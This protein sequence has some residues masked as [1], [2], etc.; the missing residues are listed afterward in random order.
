MAEGEKIDFLVIGSQKCA[1]TWLYDCLKDCPTLNLRNSKNEDA[2]YGGAMFREKGEKWYFSQFDNKDGDLQKGCI[3]VEYIEDSAVPA[4][5]YQLNPDI[6]I[7]ASL[8]H[9]V[10]RALS[11][12]QWYVRKSYIPDLPLQQGIE[13]AMK[14]FRGEI[15]DS[16]TSAYKNIIE[17][18]F[19]AERLSIWYGTFPADQI[20][21]NF[22]DEVKKDP[23]KTIQEIIAFLGADASFLPPNL[24]TIPKKNTG[25]APLIKLQRKFPNSRV[26][27]KIVDLT[28][29]LLFKHQKTASGAKVNADTREELNSLYK[30]SIQ[31]LAALFEKYNPTA[32]RNLK[33]FWG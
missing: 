3:S 19:Y 33:E 23:L 32:K 8:R 4:L 11:A 6:K 20:K 30:P 26:I 16:F 24:N 27:S 2:Y 22:F 21:I 5:L 10:D 29:Q 31:V 1:T 13:L 15:E 12:Y 14:H 7:I 9:P 28:N 18:G 25:Y 17:R